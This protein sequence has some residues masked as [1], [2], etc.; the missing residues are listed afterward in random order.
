MKNKVSGNRCAA[1]HLACA[2]FLGFLLFGCGPNDHSDTGGASEDAAIIAVE[3]KDVAGV[4]QKGPLVTGSIVTVQEL[5]GI[6]L[7]QTGKS[8][9]GNIKSDKGDFAITGINLSS[10]YAMLE[11]SGYYHDEISGKKSLG[12]ISLRAITDLSNRK[13]VNINL[14][15]HL[16]YE[17]VLY[18][19]TKKNMSIA[20][21]KA[22]A[23]N[24][25]FTVFGIEGDFSEFEDLNIFSSGDEN[26][27]LLAI[28]VLMQSDASVAELTERMGNFSIELAED[29]SWS[30]GKTKAKIADWAAKADLHETL[31]IV[32][33]NIEGWN[34]A[35]SIPPFE[36][37]V[38]NFWWD[39]YGLGT[40]SQKNE[41]EVRRNINKL[42]EL[43]NEY[44]S[45]ESNRWFIPA[46]GN[47]ESDSSAIKESSSSKEK[48]AS[49]SSA[50]IES[51]S[52]DEIK[53]S[54]SSTKPIFETFSDNRDGKTYKAVHINNQI[55]MAENLNYAAE[56]SRCYDDDESNC[57]KYGR[58]YNWLT[59]VD[60]VS[61]G[62][63]GVF[64]DCRLRN[65][66]FPRQGICPNGWRVPEQKD[67]D[68][69]L[70]FVSLNNGLEKI[71]AS[72]AT[73]MY[74]DYWEKEIASD[75][76]GFNALLGGYYNDYK[77]YEGIGKDADFWSATI[78][79]HDFIGEF[80]TGPIVYTFAP[81][82]DES[83]YF[84]WESY[85]SVRCIKQ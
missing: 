46:K 56:D 12:T 7:N 21:A 32:R 85:A 54:S 45:C 3:N 82:Y 65:D 11:A 42:S 57:E 69:L 36:K 9:K 81:G 6:T 14:L 84:T 41:G 47:S 80:V 73:Y 37:Y 25:I 77:G 33:K 26:A 64:Y 63:S 78:E 39:N 66:F 72:L 52:S 67:W 71:P 23:E 34:Y 68:S 10:Q 27:A 75:R 43:Y 30:D 18:L 79:T 20:K 31:S 59:L 38:T 60:T 15:T 62:C 5:D 1:G 58:L 2:I 8:F 17:R 53:E 48:L 50:A 51:S 35:D 55:W 28:S 61:D 76:F 83:S 22:Q 16:E 19:I 13:M 4:S 40:C 44:F 49:S 24:E 29:G 74:D 70:T